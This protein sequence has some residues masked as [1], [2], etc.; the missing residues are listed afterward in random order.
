MKVS[1]RAISISKKDT[2]FA[3]ETNGAQI[4]IIFVT[5]DIVRIRAGFDSDFA[6]ESYCW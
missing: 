3:V 6:E 2:Y 1:T 4:R 5:D